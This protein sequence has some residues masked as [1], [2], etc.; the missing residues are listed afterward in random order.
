[1]HGKDR[2][3]AALDIATSAMPSGPCH[4]PSGIV[5]DVSDSVARVARARHWWARRVKRA[6]PARS[7]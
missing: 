7:A 5:R 2:S 1:M 3:R 6:S 4:S